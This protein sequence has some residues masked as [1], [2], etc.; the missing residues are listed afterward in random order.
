VESATRE[1]LERAVNAIK[2]NRAVSIDWIF[3]EVWKGGGEDLFEALY[4]F[5]LK[6]GIETKCPVT[7]REA[8]HAQFIRRAISWFVTTAEESHFSVYHI[9]SS[10]VYCEIG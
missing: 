8:I 6:C 1:E 10:H 7:G 3:L 9:N 4:G 2:V 5:K